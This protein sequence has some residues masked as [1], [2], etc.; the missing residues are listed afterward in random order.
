MS[1]LYFNAQF[2]DKSV[3]FYPK[4]QI[5]PDERDEVKGK[6]RKIFF[7]TGGS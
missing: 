4:P 5:S 1:G 3:S 2:I 7:C 6:F